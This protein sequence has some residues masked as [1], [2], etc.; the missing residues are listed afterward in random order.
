MLMKDSE[1]TTKVDA[2]TGDGGNIT[3]NGGVV[4]LDPSQIDATALGS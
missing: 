3:I 2:F 4:V 1:I